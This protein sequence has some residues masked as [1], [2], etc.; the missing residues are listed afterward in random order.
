MSN[1]YFNQICQNYEI[2]VIKPSIVRNDDKTNDESTLYQ[3]PTL[4]TSFLSSP[5][6]ER[7]IRIAKSILYPKD[8]KRKKDFNLYRAIF[9]ERN[10]AKREILKKKLRKYIKESEKGFTEIEEK[11][12]QH[13]IVSERTYCKKLQ[14]YQ[15]LVG[16][17]NASNF[18][19]NVPDDYLNTFINQK[20]LKG[21]LQS[22]IITNISKSLR[23]YN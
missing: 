5:Y 20:I 10:P 3:T 11:R 6:R 1:Q 15:K 8:R 12:Y 4:T 16:D 18:V 19:I 17:L 13:K 2:E 22:E 14:K 21:G 23:I 9:K 7:V